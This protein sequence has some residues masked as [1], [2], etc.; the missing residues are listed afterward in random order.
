MIDSVLKFVTS[1]YLY[2]KNPDYQ[3]GPLTHSR[4]QIISNKS[5]A[6]LAK[7]IDLYQY[8]ISGVTPRRFW[9]PPNFQCTSDESKKAKQWLTYHSIANNTLADAMESALGA[10]FLSGSLNGVVRAIRQFDIPMGI[11]TWTDIHA[12]YQLSPKSTLISWQID[13][14]SVSEILGYTFKD[15]SL[16]QEAL[17]HRSASNGTYERLE[18]LGDALLD[19]YVT[20]YIY[21]G[22]PTATPSILHSL[23]KSSV[24]HHILS[25]ICL[26]MK[27]HKHIVYSAGSI[28]AAVMKF[29]Y[30]HQRVVDSGEDV[31]EYWLALDPPKMLS[32]VVESLLGAML[33]DSGF[34]VNRVQVFF[35]RWIKPVLD[36]HVSLGTMREHPMSLFTKKIQELGCMNWITE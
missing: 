14:V 9:R 31:D 32:D 15:N 20:T 34:D 19:Y 36:Q 23:R 7:D 21:Q 29:E 24:N 18:F 3:E 1:A 16:L 13:L 27:L 2:V 11:K 26:K 28:A 17:M 4:T 6:R 12:I 5:L 30:D 25:V 35:N 22:H 10:A 8:I 33:V